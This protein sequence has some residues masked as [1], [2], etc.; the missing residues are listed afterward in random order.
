V[1]PSVSRADVVHGTA[2]T[3]RV[4]TPSESVTFKPGPL[5]ASG[6]GPL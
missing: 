2:L 1:N 4:E 3:V 6:N 5:V